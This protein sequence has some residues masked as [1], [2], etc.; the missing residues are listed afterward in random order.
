MHNNS[1]EMFNRDLYK[2]KGWF[3]VM[4]PLFIYAIYLV[5]FIYGIAVLLEEIQGRLSIVCFNTQ[6]G[7]TLK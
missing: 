1:I 4:S 6:I 2:P 7:H 5:F 3:K